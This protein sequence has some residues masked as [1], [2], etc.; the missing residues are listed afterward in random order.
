[1]FYCCPSSSGASPNIDATVEARVKEAIAAQPTATPVV[2]VKKVT[3]TNSPIPTNTPVPAVRAT[4]APTPHPW[5][6]RVTY[7]DNAVYFLPP[8]TESK[9]AQ[10]LD[11]LKRREVI[12][13]PTKKQYQLRLV[14]GVYEIRNGL[15]TGE[16]QRYAMPNELQDWLSNY[17]ED[18]TLQSRFAEY[19]CARQEEDFDGVTTVIIVLENPMTG[20]D[21]VVLR[22]TCTTTPPVIPFASL[23]IG[24]LLDEVEANE[25][26]AGQTYKDTWISVTGHISHLGGAQWPRSGYEIEI[27]DVG[28]YEIKNSGN[29]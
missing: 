8:V 4:P 6:G 24:D 3:P 20:F 10:Y 27:V 21:D 5:G 25:I 7:F 16:E 13:Q 19:A 14:D 9:A 23:W 26:L 22:V 1:M 12:E 2:V 11:S 17:E 28:G 18:F 29:I 15:Y